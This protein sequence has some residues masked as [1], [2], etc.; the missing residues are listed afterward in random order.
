M[1]LTTQT[2]RTYLWQVAG[3]DPRYTSFLK[4]AGIE[5]EILQK[6]TKFDDLMKVHGD[7][8]NRYNTY[9]NMYNGNHW[10]STSDDNIEPI[11]VNFC[12]MTI[13][14]NV[15]F[16]MNKGFLVESDFPDIEKFLQ[17]NWLL[18]GG[19][20]A[21]NNP[22][23]TNLALMGGINGDAWVS[24][25][26]D[27]HPVTQQEYIKY[28][29]LKSNR[30]FPVLDR[31]KP[32]GYLDYGLRDV[33]VALNNGFAEYDKVYEG[34]FYA[35]GLKQT[36]KDD[37]VVGTQL[38][39]FLE[40]PIVHFANFPLVGEY[41]GMGDL[42][43]VVDLNL[44]YDR[45]ITDVQDI[46]DYHSSPITILKGAR[47]SELTRG[48]NK[49][50]SIPKDAEIKNLEL[51]GDLTSATNH[52]MKIRESIAEISN[53]PVNKTDHIS[54]T[55]AAA[56]AI[57]FMPLYETMEFKRTFYGSKLLELNAITIKYAI[58]KG[59]LSVNKIVKDALKKWKEDYKDADELTRQKNYPFSEKV[60]AS[61]NYDDLTAFYNGEIPKEIF[62]TYITWFP[63][64][65][66]D[67]KSVADMVIALT[68][69]NLYSK[70]HGRSVIGLSDKESRLVEKEIEQDAERNFERYAERET[71]TNNS[72]FGDKT[73]MEGDND[74]KG[75]KE[76]RRVEKKNE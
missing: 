45:L 63:P 56:L 35:P 25:L 17:D 6:K 70:R 75:E 69:A 58:L 42:A 24:A 10:F 33:V 16:L 49:V 11:K 43:Q 4:A 13:N 30:A 5:G 68:N 54:N 44:L 12:N 64:L 52:I 57:Q 7:R 18:N 3:D 60:D 8:I 55:S 36:I 51:S 29:I 20:Q 14:K 62:E 72:K 76:S 1:A 40:M 48:A 21:P 53:V 28:D 65:P 26:L 41:Y 15:A 61:K 67:E 73:G 74:V 47:A 31:G 38:F 19:G 71:I 23:G 2:L 46:I 66:R 50:W 37:V 22:F 32:I 34:A 27:T 9:I 59:K 39:D